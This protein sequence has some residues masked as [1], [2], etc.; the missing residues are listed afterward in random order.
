MKDKRKTEK[1]LLNESAEIR[2]RVAG[3]AQA[4]IERVQVEETP[5]EVTMTWIR[6]GG[7]E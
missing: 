7:T 4:E 1:Q 2:R 3:S 6:K 5:Q